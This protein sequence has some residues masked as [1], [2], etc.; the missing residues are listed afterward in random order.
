VNPRNIHLLVAVLAYA[1]ANVDDL[2]EAIDH[3]CED[4]MGG[5]ATEAELQALLAHFQH[6]EIP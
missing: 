5:P 3:Y 1:V 4:K 2:N 6:M